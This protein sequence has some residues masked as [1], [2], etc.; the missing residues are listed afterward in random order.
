MNIK[1]IG[2]FGFISRLASRCSQKL[3]DGYTGIGDDCAIIPGPHGS[4]YAIST[5]LLIEG[6]HFVTKEIGGYGLG[7]K[8][9]AA[10]LSDLAAAGATPC[11]AFMSIALPEDTNTVFLDSFADGFNAL[12]QKYGCPLL[13]GDTTLSKSGITVNICIIGIRD[14]GT[15]ISRA[16]SQI[17]DIICVTGDLGDSGAGLEYILNPEWNRDEVA[18]SLIKR[19]HYPEPRIEEGKYLAESKYVHSMM[20]LS[21]GLA[22]DIKHILE[23]SGVSAEIELENLPTSQLLQQK[24]G[25][26]PSKL[27]HYALHGGEDYELLL[28]V[29]AK[30]FADLNVNYKKRFGKSLHAVGRITHGDPQHVQYI[31]NGFGTMP[32]GSPWA[33]FC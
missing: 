27:Y 21:D 22:S 25:S 31:E 23:R 30:H 9:L 1:D 28:T 16:N 33:H 18:T 4:Q 13:G 12:G 5:D 7:Y 15:N 3:C 2:E 24:Y 11:G 32:L 19:H 20:D 26:Q 29:D 8:S 14:K 6:V 10:N 17:G